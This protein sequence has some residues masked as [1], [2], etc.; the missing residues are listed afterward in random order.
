MKQ[1]A[2]KLLVLICLLAALACVIYAQNSS[3][4]PQQGWFQTVSSSGVAVW[5]RDGGS[6]TNIQVMDG[7]GA[8][9]V[10]NNQTFTGNNTFSRPIVVSNGIQYASIAW[11]GPT[12]TL[13]LNSAR[14]HYSSPTAVS[15]TGFTGKSTTNV[16]PFTL[17]ILNTSATNWVFNFASGVA[18]LN[19][20]TSYTVTNG[21]ELIWSGEYDP[22]LTRTNALARIAP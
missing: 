5:T 15:V 10:T 19:Y 21:T 22:Y 11:A 12:N 9:G 14:Q 20:V 2:K 7:S 1:L 18:D 6:L 8:A 13:P 16:Q 17:C 4:P 3:S